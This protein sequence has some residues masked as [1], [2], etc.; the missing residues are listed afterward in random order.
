MLVI[1]SS[2]SFSPIQQP[3]S[4]WKVAVI[5][6]LAAFFC[7]YN[8]G[9]RPIKPRDEAIHSRVVQEMY[10]GGSWFSPTLDGEVY[11]QKPPFKMWLTVLGMKA[12]GESAFTY[13]LIDGIVGL[14]T[15]LIVYLLAI[16]LFSSQTTAFFSILALLSSQS[17][18]FDH[19]VRDGVQDSMLVF[20]SS[21]GLLCLWKFFRALEQ[22]QTKKSYELSLCF[23]LCL[24]L[25]L[26]TKGV[27]GFYSAVILMLMV[28]TSSNWRKLA[29]KAKLA[30]GLGFIFALLIAASYFVPQF[31]VSPLVWFD[32]YSINV[33]K[34]LL[35]HGMHNRLNPFFYFE[36]FIAGTIFNP[37]VF[38]LAVL[39]ALRAALA[40]QAT[41]RFLLIWSLGS[42]IGLSLL[43]SRLTWYLAPA[44]PAMA[45]MLGCLANYSLELLRSKQRAGKFIGALFLVIWVSLIGHDLYYA[46]RRILNEDRGS[47]IEKLTQELQAAKAFKSKT[48]VLAF[49]RL[50]KNL[51]QSR[52]RYLRDSIYLKRLEPIAIKLE[53]LEQLKQFFKEYAK[54][55]KVVLSMPQ[56]IDDVR[57]FKEKCRMHLK[58]NAKRELETQSKAAVNSGMKV[59]TFGECGS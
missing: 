19:V 8:L 10:Y 23:G 20:L 39:F 3:Q 1:V 24:G 17:F 11:Y 35:G 54:Q 25:A 53:S 40:K 38:G 27:A 32:N 21:T 4:F 57:S 13:R 30:L 29:Y 51:W 36:E 47:N 5:F 45:I 14:G 37:W 43:K 50:D 55:T 12:F 18:I 33:Q 26:L 46:A 7:F 22:D 58:K 41:Y 28:A 15:C 31:Y 2:S 34:R 16:S 56:Y 9:A 49:Y 6:L 59:V 42:I 44:Y 48:K 52:L